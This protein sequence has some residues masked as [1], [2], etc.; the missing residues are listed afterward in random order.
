MPD[1]PANPPANQAPNPVNA[2]NPPPPP[3]R[4]PASGG[5][6]ANPL[7][8][9]DD[10][11]A[12]LGTTVQANKVATQDAVSAVLAE[13][14]QSFPSATAID[15][16]SLAW[17]CYHNGS[18]RY[19]TL[20]G[21]SA[22]GIPLASIK[23]VVENH[24]TLRQFCMYYAKLCYNKGRSDKIPPAN[25]AAKGFKAESMYAAFDFFNGVLNEAVP[26]PRTG[27]K[28]V[29]TEAEKA[30][31]AVNAIM[32]ITESRQQA[33]QFSNRGNMLAMQ[34]IR[35]PAPPPLITFDN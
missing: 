35:T 16:V 2:P 34:Q 4:N 10:E 7:I 17:A 1:T 8:P 3:P 32:A 6:S 18:S 12:T 27:M 24:C 11:L 22:H 21:S 14:Q 19:V 28:F 29:P 15:L 26:K 23:D 20:E 25:W 13:L 30:A 31:H 33:N 5:S 9:A